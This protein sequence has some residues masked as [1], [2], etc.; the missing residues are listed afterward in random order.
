MRKRSLPSSRWMCGNACLVGF[1]RDRDRRRRL[2]DPDHRPLRAAHY[3]RSRRSPGS[4][5]PSTCG[6]RSAPAT[7]C[8]AQHPPTRW[9]CSSTARA[10]RPKSPSTSRTRTTAG[11]QYLADAG[12]D[13]FSMDVTGIGRSTRPGADERSVQSVAAA[14]GAVRSRADRRAVPAELPETL[15]PS[16]TDWDDI[17]A[18]VDY[19]RALRHVDKV[20]TVPGRRAVR[21]P[22][23]MRRSIPRRSTGW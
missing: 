6:R 4:R 21:A 1:T 8:G 2:E 14:A 13:T 3:R 23:A 20:S 11:W 18:V 12:F 19:V 7:R 22:A 16:R 15:R 17:D 10:R 9:L 5:P